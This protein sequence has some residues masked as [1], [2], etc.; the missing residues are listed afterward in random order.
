MNEEQD[1]VHKWDK[2]RPTRIYQPVYQI[3]TT[4]HY[5]VDVW[6]KVEI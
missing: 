6:Q 2:M 5:S 4:V 3:G 1:I